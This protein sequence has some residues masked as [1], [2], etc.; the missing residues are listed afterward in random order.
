MQKSILQD[1]FY[2][3]WKEM[4]HKFSKVATTKNVFSSVYV[5]GT[6]LFDKCCLFHVITGSQVF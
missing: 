1:I 4:A 6:N 5:I 2:Y 3:V